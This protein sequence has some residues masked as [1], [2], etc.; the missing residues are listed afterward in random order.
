MLAALWLFVVAAASSEK[1]HA[2]LHPDVHHAS[3]DCVLTQVASGQ[4]EV[5]EGG[6]G[7]LEPGFLGW[8][9]ST[10]A[11]LPVLPAPGGDVF[12]ARGPPRTPS[13]LPS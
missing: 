6:F 7:P 2:L 11:A 3:H 12:S 4:V 8:L 5:P 13:F 10:M 1:L 9:R